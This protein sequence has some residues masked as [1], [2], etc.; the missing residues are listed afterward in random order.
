MA[1]NIKIWNGFNKSDKRQCADNNYYCLEWGT[2]GGII[3]NGS[4]GIIYYC[5]CG[6]E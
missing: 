5:G 4:L 1:G 2:Y 6:Q 3:T